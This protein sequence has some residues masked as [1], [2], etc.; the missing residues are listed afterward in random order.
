[1]DASVTPAG[2]EW[3]QCLVP[4]TDA[5]GPLAADVRRS[6]G[7]VPAFLP[8]LA[9]APWTARAFARIIAAPFAHLSPT[10]Q[11]RLAMVVSQ[12][13]SCRY[14]YG[15]QRAVLRIFG[16]TQQQ[17]DRI[18][19]DA[20]ASDASPAERAALD[21]ARRL[22]RASPRPGRAEL[23]AVVAAGMAPAAVAEVAAMTA[24]ASFMNRVATLL[25]LPTEP[26]EALVEQ[27]FFRLIRPLV[28]WRMRKPAARPAA[29]PPPA[30]G[31][32]SRVVA[33]LGVSPSAHALRDILD[34][35]WASPILPP[36][37]KML[38]LAVVARALGC[39]HGEDE[40]R[41]A[42][43]GEGLSGADVDEV[44]ST[45]SSPRLD[46]R[47]ACLVPFAR[48]TIR[49]QPAVIQQRTREACRGLGPAETVE[50][51]GI[52]ALANAVCRLSVVLGTC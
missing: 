11:T 28:A 27:R 39:A 26:I 15:T 46:A 29:A 16:H 37:T 22:S 36:R 7:A 5:P 38:V 30:G 40:A 48:E 1:M 43:A 51:V 25:A 14:C 12:D 13:N 19:R 45:L 42:L 34:D 41:H 35:A 21:F 23:D 8:R 9:N 2:E 6:V 17:I 10:F 24:F 47:E 44:L 52:I 32:C 50:A 33:A 31:P 18:V 4:P 49:Y 3:S 20:A